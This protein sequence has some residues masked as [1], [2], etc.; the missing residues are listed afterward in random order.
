MLVV[1]YLSNW[2]AVMESA[3][4][5][6]YRYGSGVKMWRYTEA[7][8]ALLARWQRIRRNWIPA[9]SPS[10]RS[11]VA[12]G[13][14]ALGNSERGC[15][16]VF[17]VTQAVNPQYPRERRYSAR[18]SAETVRPECCMGGA[19]GVQSGGH[20][21]QLAC[22]LPSHVLLFRHRNLAAYTIQ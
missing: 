11:A 5:S 7:L 17:R 22:D 16:E 19:A 4:L 20:W 2:P 9:N 14:A 3:P 10:V 15:V 12:R 8:G 1:E 6:S 18:K 13:G 21:D